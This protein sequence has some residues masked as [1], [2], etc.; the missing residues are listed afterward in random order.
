MKIPFFFDVFSR[1][2]WGALLGEAWPPQGCREK[3][4]KKE[5]NLHGES[6]LTLHSYG[7]AILY[8]SIF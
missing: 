8:G 1:H 2:P 3:N 5:R 4:I 7:K 6:F